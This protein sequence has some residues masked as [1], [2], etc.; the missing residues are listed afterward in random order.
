MW[1]PNSCHLFTALLLLFSHSVVS[2]YLQPRRLQHAR[3][4]CPSLSPRVCSDSRPFSWW[5]HPT[6]SSSVVTFFSCPQSF[7]AS[8]S[9]SVSQLFP[10][11][12]QSIGVSALASVLQMNIQGWFPLGLTG[13]ILLSKEEFQE[14]SP[15]PQFEGINF[16]E[17]NF[18]CGPTFIS[19]HDY[20]KN[21]SFVSKKS[22]SAK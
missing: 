16:L 3:L 17:L 6:T 18:L 10:S 19:I 21:Y 20:W 13:L 8:E 11:G 22:L 5:C 15:A 2:D 4:P 1:S 14:Y 7:P 9:F 12:G